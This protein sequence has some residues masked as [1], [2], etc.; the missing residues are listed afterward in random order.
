LNDG[1][2]TIN[3]V[4]FVTF[5]KL[6]F[7]VFALKSRLYKVALISERSHPEDIVA[8]C[9]VGPKLTFISPVHCDVAVI[10]PVQPVVVYPSPNILVQYKLL[11]GVPLRV[12]IL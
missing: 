6:W 10:P 9:E 4:P 1:P 5:K 2:Q 11:I 12:L 7:G 8:N 3:W